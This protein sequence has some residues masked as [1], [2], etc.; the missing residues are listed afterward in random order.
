MRGGFT[1]PNALKLWV[2]ANYD[3]AVEVLSDHQAMS[4]ALARTDPN[5]F[6]EFVLR[7]EETQA[8]VLQEPTHQ[9]MQD[10][11]TANDRLVIH[12]HIESG[13]TTSVGVGRVLFEI[14]KNPNLRCAFVS[15]TAHAAAKVSSTVRRYIEQSDELHAVFPDLL[16]G[17]KWTDSALTVKRASF[18]RDYSLCAIGVGSQVLGS[19]LDFVVLDDVLSMEATHSEMAREQIAQWYSA[20]IG[21]RLTANARIVMMGTAW[22]EDDLLHRQLR[23][24]WAH[25]HIPVKTDDG[26]LTMPARWTQERIDKWIRDN[27]PLEASR[28]LFV[29]AI[30]DATRRFQK[31]WIDKCLKR[32]EGRPAIYALRH[33][34]GGCRVYTGVDLGTSEKTSSDRTVLFTGLVYPNGDREVLNIE[35]GQWTGPTIIEKIKDVHRR[36]GG[37]VL[38]ESNA[39][40][41][42][43]K[44]FVAKGSA[45]PVM[46]FNTGKNKLDE[47]FG[48]E[49]MGVEFYNEKWIIPSRGGIGANDEINAWI[50]EMLNYTPSTHTGDRLMAAWF[51][52]QGANMR[53]RKLGG[54]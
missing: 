30:D 33:I 31:G 15:K 10:A 46:E 36:Y 12:C 40:Q 20:N 22:H 13:K 29:R 39:A 49:S 42:F 53:V 34:P 14:G 16:P 17:A 19:R 35:S 47:H 51:F 32:G 41:V 2:E 48:L 6:C 8:H 44:Q 52:R 50:S 1:N 28:Q 24:G 26:R 45:L 25:V 5:E 21:G 11:I 4:I 3:E 27:G 38:V 7:D 43:I 18:A 23:R 37:I 9:A 54:R